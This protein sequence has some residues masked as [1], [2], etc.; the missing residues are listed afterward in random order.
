MALAQGQTRSVPRDVL[1]PGK[2]RVS[3]QVNDDAGRR[4]RLKLTL[5][6]P[7]PSSC[8]LCQDLAIADQAGSAVDTATSG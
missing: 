4:T 3:I 5:R 1:P 8:D 7:E 6:V 2:H